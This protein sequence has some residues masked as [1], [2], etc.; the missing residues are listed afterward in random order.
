MKPGAIV[1]A[2]AVV[3]AAMICTPAAVRLMAE[4]LLI[5]INAPSVEYVPK[6]V[7]AM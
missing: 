6:S 3:I 7:A 4:S 5:M 1:R 2:A